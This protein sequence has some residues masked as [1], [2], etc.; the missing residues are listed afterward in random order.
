MN[1]KLSEC[2]SKV[3][4]TTVKFE[5]AQSREAT[6]S[7]REKQF[8]MD[9]QRLMNQIQWLNDELQKKSTQ[10][11]QNKS[12]HN[13]KVYELEAKQD[14]LTAENK[15]NKSLVE[16]LQTANENMEAQVEDLT[17]KLQEVLFLT[18]FE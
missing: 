6:I 5:E 18:H 17:Q 14:E 15:K 1:T 12:D 7:F 16:N 10:I 4:E 11:L 3:M 13:K 9:K 2:E 8:E